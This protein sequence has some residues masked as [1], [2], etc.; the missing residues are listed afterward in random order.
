MSNTTGGKAENRKGRNPDKVALAS[1]FAIEWAEEILDVLV[2][3]YNATPHT[4]HSGDRTPLAQAKFLYSRNP[5]SFRKLPD[6]T[7]A[8]IGFSARKLCKVKGGGETGRLPYVN[9]YNARYTNEL[10]QNRLDLLGKEIWVV[11]H[12]EN[13][14]RV[15]MGSTIEGLSLGILR[16]APPWHGYPHSLAVRCEI[17]RLNGRLNFMLQAGA[18]GVETFLDFVDA[19]PQSKLPVYPA[20]LEARRILALAAQAI[21]STALRS[22]ALDFGT[23]PLPGEEV[24]QDKAESVDI[25]TPTNQER[26]GRKDSPPA[27]TRRATAPVSRALPPPRKAV[28]R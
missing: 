9:F 2:A 27:P 8:L 23:E 5:D 22:E 19:Q 4:S 11:N 7:N 12:L 13:D 26:D 16:A 1:K 25:L 28:S 3:N 21:E 17:K 24:A 15:A 6:S 10:L 20:Y 14:A 18:D